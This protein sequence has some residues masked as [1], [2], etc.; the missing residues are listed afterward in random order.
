MGA[1]SQDLRERIMASC[2]AKEG[3]QAEIAE[4]YKV[5]LGMVKKLRGQRKRIGTIENLRHRCGRKPYFTP[6]IRSEI[7]NL[8]EK[9][10]DLTLGQIRETLNLKCTLV[11]IFYVLKDMGFTYKKNATRKRTATRG[12]R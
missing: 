12:C 4:R 5:S 8:V 9:R 3:T 6:E 10:N 1:I 11:A 7:K 2:D